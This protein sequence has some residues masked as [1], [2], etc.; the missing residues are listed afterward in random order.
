MSH[1][2]AR[3]CLKAPFRQTITADRAW[4][5]PACVSSFQI[6][7]YSTKAGLSAICNFLFNLQG[8][9]FSSTTRIPPISSLL[10]CLSLSRS[11][12][13]LS[14]SGCEEVA[15]VHL[16]SVHP[17]SVAADARQLPRDDL[18]DRERSRAQ[19]SLGHGQAHPFSQR[20]LRRSLW[21]RAVC[22]CSAGGES[23]L[24][25]LETAREKVWFYGLKTSKPPFVPT[26]RLCSYEWTLSEVQRA[27]RP[28][29]RSCYLISSV[30]L[31]TCYLYSAHEVLNA[32]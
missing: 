5:Y 4:L 1:R 12:L 15:P 10:F 31:V 28:P 14:F 9:S 22:Y 21:H 29:F 6:T 13:F 7:F 8:L 11:L 19:D 20:S 30:L 17:S 23:F 16:R 32:F 3:D 26:G 24:I 25:K 27:P 2:A 18:W